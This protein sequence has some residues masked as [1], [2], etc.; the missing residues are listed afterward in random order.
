[1]SGLSLGKNAEKEAPTG[2]NVRGGRLGPDARC[3]S[4]KVRDTAHFEKILR[5]FS[6]ETWFDHVP[7]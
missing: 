4:E 6:S 1:M 3:D 2:A 5:R 7:Y